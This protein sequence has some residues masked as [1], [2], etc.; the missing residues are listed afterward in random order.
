MCCAR[1]FSTNSLFC[2]ATTNGTLALRERIG[3][4]APHPAIADG[5]M[6]DFFWAV[7]D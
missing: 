4:A 1:S 7:L 3:D 6:V 2:S 5:L